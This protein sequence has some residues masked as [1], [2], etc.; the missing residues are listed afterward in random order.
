ML[1]C[2][3]DRIYPPEHGPLAEVI[4]ASGAIVSELPPGAPPRPDHFPRRNRLISGLVARRGRRRGVAPERL[5]HHGALRADQGREVMAVPGT[6]LGDRHRGS[7]SLHPRRRRRSSRR[8]RTSSPRS[9]C[10]A[11]AGRRRRTGDGRRP[12]GAAADVDPILAA[13]EGGETPVD[14]QQLEATTGLSAGRAAAPVC[15][16]TRWPG[17]SCG[18]P[19]GR[20]FR[21]A[22][23]Q[24]W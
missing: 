13:L 23:R 3:L 16:R 11:P 19:G 6:V 24:Q 22:S 1:G 9:A 21:T 2:G 17:A 7:H 15:W 14:L 8:P 12:D 10:A 5:A 20:F 18:V 4:A